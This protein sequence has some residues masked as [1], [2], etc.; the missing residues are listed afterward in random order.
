MRKHDLKDGAVYASEAPVGVPIPDH[1]RQRIVATFNVHRLQ[2][3]RYTS[4]IHSGLSF[5]ITTDAS[6]FYLWYVHRRVDLE[7][8]QAER[9]PV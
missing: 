2:A 7:V 9:D 3:A 5:L 6:V 1:L 4:G 8:L